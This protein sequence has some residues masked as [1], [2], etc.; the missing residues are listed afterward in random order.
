VCSWHCLWATHTDILELCQLSACGLWG[1][2]GSI[3]S[4]SFPW[5]K[6]ELIDINRSQMDGNQNCT[7]IIDEAL[8]EGLV[9]LWL[10]RVEVIHSRS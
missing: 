10:W 7:S 4:P 5:L 3:N 8:L 2:K 1:K 9:W 6:S